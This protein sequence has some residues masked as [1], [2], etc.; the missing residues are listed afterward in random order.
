MRFDGAVFYRI[1]LYVQGTNPDIARIAWPEFEDVTHQNDLI[2]QVVAVQKNVGKFAH[3]SHR[4][5]VNVMRLSQFSVI[6]FI[7]QSDI[8]VFRCQIS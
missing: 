5:F 7:M 6:F 1:D 2:T 3:K 4:Q 8:I